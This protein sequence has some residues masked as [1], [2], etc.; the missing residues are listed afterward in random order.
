MKFRFFA[1][2]F[3]FL[4]GCSATDRTGAMDP[5]QEP[6]I[7]P[8]PPDDADGDSCATN[9]VPLT[10]TYSGGRIS[11][12]VVPVR[13]GEEEGWLA[14][15]TGSALTFLYG[16]DSLVKTPIVVGCETIEVITRDFPRER[17]QGKPIVGVMGAD[18]FTSKTTDF[19][20]PGGRIVRHTK[21]AP[22]GTEGYLEVPWIDA[23]GHIAVRAEVD[24]TSHVL[25]VDTG[26]PHVLL[27]GVAGRPTDEQTGIQ[28]A[29][30]NIVDAWIGDSE[31]VL[32]GEKKVAPVLRV[33]D[34]P[35]FESYA[36]SLHPEM[37]GLFGTSAIG[38]RR[39]VV[40]PAAH[41]LRLGPV[42]T[43]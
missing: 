17:F 9:V 8:A 4:L 26:S 7:V 6:P 23:A 36:T 25:M 2:F 33:P 22:A 5:G 12:Q 43:R 41:V 29:G 34:W 21:D 27:V 13:A 37:A 20:Y 35:Y 31:V 14:I 24:G 16:P 32:G 1:F 40:D 19:D 10:V 18:F 3:F 15:D 38:F 30:G 11:D 28:D 42:Q 39:I